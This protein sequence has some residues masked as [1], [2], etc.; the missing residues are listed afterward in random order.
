MR[1]S[2]NNKKISK[3]KIYPKISLASFGLLTHLLKGEDV[4]Q[5]EGYDCL[6]VQGNFTNGITSL[7]TIVNELEEAGYL[8]RQQDK[9]PGGKFCPSTIII[10]RLPTLNPYR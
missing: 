2:T 6:N 5:Y 1:N 10:Y 9:N 8:V 4:A 3:T 7:R